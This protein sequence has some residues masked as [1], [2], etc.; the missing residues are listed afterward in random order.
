M[1]LLWAG[2]FLAAVRLRP[3]ILHHP[4]GAGIAFGILV[5]LTMRLVVLPLSAFPHP[6]AFKP[7]ATTLDLLSHMLLFGVPMAWVFRGMLRAGP[8]RA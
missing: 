4:V 6:V 7:L 1:S 2:V 3:R 8:A 5:F